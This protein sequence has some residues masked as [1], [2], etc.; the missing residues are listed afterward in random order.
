M[1]SPRP[2]TI[3]WPLPPASP[4]SHLSWVFPSL[5]CTQ[6]PA[7][8]LNVSCPKAFPDL[9]PPPTHPPT[10]RPPSLCSLLNKKGEVSSQERGPAAHSSFWTG[11]LVGEGA[12]WASMSPSSLTV[13]VWLPC[14]GVLSPLA[15]TE[16][17]LS[18]PPQ[19]EQPLVRTAP[20]LTLV[21]CL[22]G[23]CHLQGLDRE[24]SRSSPAGLPRVSPFSPSPPAPSE[25]G[26]W[27]P[28]LADSSLISSSSPAACP[29]LLLAADSLHYPQQQILS[30]LCPD[31]RKWHQAARPKKW[32]S[33]WLLFSFSRFLPVSDTLNK[34]SLNQTT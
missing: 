25:Q 5:Q 24:F 33:S 27:D 11:G 10:H 34:H 1:P 21:T 4:P 13:S 29:H 19:L 17:A 22:A 26:A 6:Q 30:L 20:S 23:H 32:G 7:T 28:P 2:A 15:A 14:R 8:G 12:L 18:P 16:P 31:L 9:K 3:T